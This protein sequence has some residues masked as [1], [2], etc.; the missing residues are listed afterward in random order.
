MGKSAATPAIWLC[1][2]PALPPSKL[3]PWARPRW[4][5]HQRP[6]TDWGVTV[7]A[8]PQ[9]A[10]WKSAA[11]PVG[12]MS[13][14]PQGTCRVSSPKQVPIPH[15]C[16]HPPCRG[17]LCSHTCAPYGFT[18]ASSLTEFKN[19]K[20]GP[21]VGQLMNTDVLWIS[22]ATASQSKLL[23]AAPAARFPPSA[24]PPPS[25]RSLAA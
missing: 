13:P 23:E 15:L 14:L 20:P 21:S 8:A 12:Q 3:S 4:P 19:I 10:L 9:E 5:A 6:R 2:G 11:G 18:S 25:I 16:P 7:S 24:R 17:M 1:R 22:E